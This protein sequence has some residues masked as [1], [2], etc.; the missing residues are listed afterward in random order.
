MGPIRTKI[1]SSFAVGFQYQ[2]SSKCVMWFSLITDKDTSCKERVVMRK[3]LFRCST[4]LCTFTHFIGR[5]LLLQSQLQCSYALCNDRKCFVKYLPYRKSRGSSVGIATGDGLERS[6]STASRPDL[7]PT[8]HLIQRVPRTFSPRVKRPGRKG[9]HLP[10]S[11]TE[12]QN[13]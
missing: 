1:H 3:R 12:V 11:S 8:Q 10:P 4:H 6:G 9:D 7:G 2:I 5:V 13:V